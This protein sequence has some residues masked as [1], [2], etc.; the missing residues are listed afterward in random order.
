[1]TNTN[2]HSGSIANT[3]LF[4]TIKSCI[5]VCWFYL[6]K[7]RFDCLL[8]TKVYS[9]QPTEKNSPLIKGRLRLGYQYPIPIQITTIILSKFYQIFFLIEEYTYNYSSFLSLGLNQC[10]EKHNVLLNLDSR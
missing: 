7:Q 2:I 8:P 9:F 6:V 10:L 3:D 1:M 4:H 5:C